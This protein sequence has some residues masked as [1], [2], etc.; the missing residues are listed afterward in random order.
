MAIA[1]A[2]G[3]SLHLGTAAKGGGEEVHGRLGG[4]QKSKWGS[5]SWGHERER[6]VAVSLTRDSQRLSC[7]QHLVRTQAGSAEALTGWDLEGSGKWKEPQPGIGHL[8]PSFTV[9]GSLSFPVALAAASALCQAGGCSDP[10]GHGILEL[11]VGAATGHW[12]QD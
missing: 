4:S 8:V 1:Q 2:Q 3:G 5:V 6:L 10:S 9:T 11:W 7:I 12:L